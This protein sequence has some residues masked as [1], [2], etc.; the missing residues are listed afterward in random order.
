M[1]ITID[2]SLCSGCGICVDACSEVFSFNAD[3]KAEAIKQS[4]DNCTLEEIA[5]QCPTNAIEVSS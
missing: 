1:S 5:D 2:Q 4:C 3:G